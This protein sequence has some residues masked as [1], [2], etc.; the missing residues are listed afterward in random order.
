MLKPELGTALEGFHVLDPE[1]E[2]VDF[3]QLLLRALLEPG[4]QLEECSSRGRRSLEPF[5][6]GRSGA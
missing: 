4:V 6:K 2:L 3:P 5:I 1:L